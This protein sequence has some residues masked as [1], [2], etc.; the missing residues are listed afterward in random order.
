M[1]NGNSQVVRKRIENLRGFTLG[2][3]TPDI[4]F[5]KQIQVTRVHLI[6][7]SLVTLQKKLCSLWP[8]CVCVYAGAEAQRVLGCSELKQS[9]LAAGVLF[10]FVFLHLLPV[11]TF[12]LFSLDNWNKTSQETLFDY[13]IIPFVL[14]I[15]QR[16]R[17][18]HTHCNII[19]SMSRL[20]DVPSW[21]KNNN[22]GKLKW[23]N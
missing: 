8:V 21:L 3:S 4:V 13:S 16:P 12:C 7:T 10:F 2:F 14:Q 6:I 5:N 11:F 1:E 17:V 18:T 23:T 19:H 15:T 22:L 20:K 9:S